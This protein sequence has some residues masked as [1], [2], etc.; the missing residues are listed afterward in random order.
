MLCLRL[1]EGHA[2]I[3][4]YRTACNNDVH[5]LRWELLSEELPLAA[6]LQRSVEIYRGIRQGRPVVANQDPVPLVSGDGHAVINDP[7]IVDIE[8]DYVGRIHT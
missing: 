6:V 5:A 8:N 2:D 3:V 4:P 1:R 7:D